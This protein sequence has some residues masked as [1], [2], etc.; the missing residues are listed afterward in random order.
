ML[1]VDYLLHSSKDIL[2]YDFDTLDLF[3]SLS[4][5]NRQENR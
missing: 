1:N 5:D 4:Q 3:V 2:S